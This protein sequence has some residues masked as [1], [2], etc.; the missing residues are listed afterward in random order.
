MRS[1]LYYI[2]SKINKLQ[3]EINILTQQLPEEYTQLDFITTTGTQ[4]IDTG[5]I[6]T[7]L[8]DKEIELTI[9]NNTTGLNQF[10]FNGVYQLG[11]STQM[12]TVA[13]S[14]TTC[15]CAINFGF[16]D[17]VGVDGLDITKFHK[18]YVKDGLQKVNNVQ[19][20]TTSFGSLN[21]YHFLLFARTN[22]A[23]TTS[24]EVNKG[25]SISLF[26]VK[27]NGKYIRY[28]VPCYRNSDNKVGMYDLATNTFYTNSG[29]GDFIAGNEVTIPN[30]VRVVT[31]ENTNEDVISLLDLNSIIN[32][33]KED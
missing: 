27:K 11:K 15:R 18:L 14:T 33:K 30:P 22:V 12:G 32:S 21:E 19:I 4:Y 31:G 16:T 3:N 24:V 17:S 8:T 25:S 6:G 2:I 13:T 23:G 26:T 5:L 29:T 10:N 20:G 1:I 7:D 28:L 9:K